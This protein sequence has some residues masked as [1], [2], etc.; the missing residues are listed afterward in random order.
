MYSTTMKIAF[1]AIACTAPA[2]LQAQFNFNVDG[3]PVQIH[4]F[5]SQGFLAT[6]DN[7]YLTTNSSHGS[8]AFTDFGANIST[9]ITVTIY[10]ANHWWYN[11]IDIQAVNCFGADSEH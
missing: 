7:N 6:N 5:A 3:R 11:P 4:S 9:Q 8:F 2:R 1:I 10:F